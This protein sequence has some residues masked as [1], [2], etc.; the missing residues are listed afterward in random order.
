M[1]NCDCGCHEGSVT[2]EL[3]IKGKRLVQ[4]G[5]YRNLTGL[6]QEMR[7]EVQG[8]REEILENR[9]TIAELKERLTRDEA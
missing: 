3:Q 9:T 6:R 8:L 1:P 7:E 4:E 2:S 5:P